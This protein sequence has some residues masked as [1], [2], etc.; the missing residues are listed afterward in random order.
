MVFQLRA[1][2]RVGAAS[3]QVTDVFDV[4]DL[5]VASVPC[6][7]LNAVPFHNG[8]SSLRSPTESV[9]VIDTISVGE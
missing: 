6:A 8:A 4:G 9:G 2:N 3:R 5:L 7:A 1:V